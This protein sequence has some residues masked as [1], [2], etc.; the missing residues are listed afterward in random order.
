MRL[1]YENL[2]HDS[3]NFRSTNLRRFRGLAQC[4][5]AT[6]VTVSVRSID[7]LSDL[8]THR[9]QQQH[10]PRLDQCCIGKIARTDT[11]T[12]SPLPPRTHPVA[13]THPHPLTPGGGCRDG[14][15]VT[16]A[17]ELKA[18]VVNGHF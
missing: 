5:L 9:H 12:P 10:V 8:P 16:V 6:S 3:E 4:I 17:S 2:F 14:A 1:D 15:G 13:P 7:Q 18:R 11:E